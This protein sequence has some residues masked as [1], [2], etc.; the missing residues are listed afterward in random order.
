LVAVKVPPQ[1]PR[2][3]VPSRMMVWPP[4]GGQL[5]KRPAV[6]LQLVKSIE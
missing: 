1:P 4:S 5:Y 2:C 3:G 6:V